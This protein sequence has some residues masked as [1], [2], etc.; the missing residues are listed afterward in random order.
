[1]NLENFPYSESAK[2]MMSYVTK[3][4]YDNSFVGKWIYEVMGIEM[5]DLIGLVDSLKDQAFPETASWGIFYHEIANGIAVNDGADLDQRRRIILNK[6]DVSHRQSMT[7]YRMESLLKSKF[8]VET[9]ITEDVGQ[10]IFHVDVLI[11]AYGKIDSS[12][13]IS[14]YIRT[15]KPSHLSFDRTFV[16]EPAVCKLAETFRLWQMVLNIEAKSQPQVNVGH[17]DVCIETH[18][19]SPAFSGN[20]KKY[21][22]LNQWNGKYRFDGSVYFDTEITEEVL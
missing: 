10:S 15:I 11:A 19:V 17:I 5:D 16:I 18:T 20:I 14:D 4:W 2:R 21:K 13:T 1:M 9:Y 8:G 6:K 22:N 3:G 7:P 12:D